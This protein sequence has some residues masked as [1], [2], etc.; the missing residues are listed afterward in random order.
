M[1]ALV[2]RCP[3]TGETFRTGFSASRDEL[4]QLPRGATIE[5]RCDVCRQR[6]V[7]ILAECQIQDD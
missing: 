5:L 6:H 7:F 1:G 2:F 4:M 3:G